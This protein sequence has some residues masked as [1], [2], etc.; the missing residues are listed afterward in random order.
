M[1]LLGQRTGELHLAFAH[2]TGDPAFDPQPITHADLTS[3]S[4]HL[5]NEAV[6]TLDDLE[7]HREN[8]SADMRAAIDRL[9][10]LR[11]TLLERISPAA[12]AGVD[13]DKMRYHGDLHMGQVLRVENDFVITDFEGEPGRTIEERH[14]K[15]SP[16]RDVAGILRS[17]S[18][19]SAVA[20]NHAT[21]ERP[22]DRHRAGPL[23]QSWEEDATAAFLKGYRLALA[24][25]DNRVLPSAAGAADHLIGFFVIEKALYEL[26]YEMD[27]RPDWLSIPLF[28]LI[29]TLEDKEE[30]YD[31]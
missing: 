6:A 2:P 17:F 29:R 15:H 20:A 23:V 14:A 8:Q 27:N 30:H 10:A 5:R 1:T 13:A 26:R 4:E 31:I 7:K 9:L 21:S 16:L 19:V 24:L 25:T 3:W 18:Y 28:S 22:A 12:L 11:K